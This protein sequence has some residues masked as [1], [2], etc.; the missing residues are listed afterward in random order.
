MTLVETAHQVLHRACTP[1]GI[2][3]SVG[4]EDNYT[5]VWSR[6]A[7]I[8][9]L[10]GYW[11]ADAKVLQALEQ[12]VLTLLAA[13]KPQGQL[14]SNVA[15]AANGTQAAV[16]YGTMSARI[17]AICWWV[18]GAAAV[19]PHT[20][21]AR[22]Q[23]LY[24][25]V[26]KAL[27]LLEALEYN[28]RGLVYVP[29]GGNWADE[30]LTHA[31]T[32]YD[33]LLRAKALQQAAVVW[34]IDEWQQ[35]A[36]QVYAVLQT[37]YYQPQHT[38]HHPYRYRPAASDAHLQ[39]PDLPYWLCSITPAGYD[40]RFDLFANALALLSPIAQPQPAATALAYMQQLA[41]QHNGLIPTFY[42]IIYPHHPE[43]WAALQA[44]HLYQFKNQP[45]CFHNGGIWAMTMGWAGIAA[46]RHQQPQWAQQWLQHL[47]THLQ[48]PTGY[49]LYEYISSVDYQAGGVPNLSFSAAGVIM[50]D[51]AARQQNIDF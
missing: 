20:T 14:P 9:G 18:I 44:H 3:A 15:V 13:Q 12:S 30:Y 37:N 8:A 19:A 11:A 50:L 5:R 33:Q 41:Q 31:Y 4:G 26:A 45:G 48:H 40:T 2:V 46:A 25:G 34:N 39:L 42:P 16:S 43:E 1:Y 6:D 21:A 36:Q 35:K 29:M 28:G 17:D 27:D 49:V 38:A 10:A 7:V 47:A 51:L 22:R 23:Q 32:L 24:V